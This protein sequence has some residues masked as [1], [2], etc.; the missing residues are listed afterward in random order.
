MS[1]I[2]RVLVLPD[3]HTPNH[4]EKTH[5]VLLKFMRDV[6]FDECVDLGDFMTST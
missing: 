4:D 2:H 5:K 6:S 1:R 3:A